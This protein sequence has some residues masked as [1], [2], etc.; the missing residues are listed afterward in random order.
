MTEMQNTANYH[1]GGTNYT[2]FRNFTPTSQLNELIAREIARIS[3]AKCLT[4]P[5]KNDIIKPYIAG[6]H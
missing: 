5:Q 3:T 4:R 1:I 6:S 2:V